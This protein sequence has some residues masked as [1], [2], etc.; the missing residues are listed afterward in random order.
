M[1]NL[2]SILKF[3]PQKKNLFHFIQYIT[4]CLKQIIT[5]KRNIGTLCHRLTDDICH[6]WTLQN[7]VK[8]YKAINNASKALKVSN[9]TL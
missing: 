7:N 8:D 4:Y 5:G 1:L 6:Q 3:I 9:D 2:H